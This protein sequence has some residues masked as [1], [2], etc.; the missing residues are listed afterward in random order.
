MNK[1]HVIYNVGSDSIDGYRDCGI[2]NHTHLL[3]ENG[4]VWVRLYGNETYLLTKGDYLETT[5]V[6]ELAF[7]NPSPDFLGK[8]MIV[9]RADIP[10]YM[11]SLQRMPLDLMLYCSVN[12]VLHLDEMQFRIMLHA[13]NEIERIDYSS[14]VYKSLMLSKAFQMFLMDFVDMRCGTGNGVMAHHSKSML[15]IFN[16]FAECVRDKG[17]K[18]HSVTYYSDRLNITPQY[19]NKIVKKLMG[20]TASTFI[21]KQL[22]T[23]LAY[24]IVCQRT[25]IKQ[26]VSDFNFS[27]LPALSSFVKRYIGKTISE[28]LHESV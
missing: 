10:L 18:E 26:I 28:L 2:I 5:R 3:V 25:P 24:E 9:K 11:E 23:N 19:L 14:H 6:G 4:E 12:P 8:F 21:R 7:S 1:G 13:F 15:R 27:S 17:N 20:E 22:V 16:A